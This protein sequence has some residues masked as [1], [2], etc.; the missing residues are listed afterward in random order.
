MPGVTP[1]TI[2]ERHNP[3]NPFIM[4]ILKETG[5]VRCVNEGTKRVRTE[6]ERAKLPPP[7]FFEKKGDNTSFVATLRND[8][9]SRSNSLDST[10]YMALGEA[11][12]LSLS[13]DERK[14]IN[15][16]TVNERVNASDALR[17]LVTT[18]WH[19]AR[20]K[21]DALVTR[22]ILVRHSTKPRDPNSYYDLKRSA[23]EPRKE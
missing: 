8:I 20:A 13:P 15:Y 2:Y 18:R 14:I 6:M 19:T 21:L 12:A 17:I 23:D 5:E 16:V 3:R 1:E 11:V 7:A 9:K 22:G 10:A 4:A